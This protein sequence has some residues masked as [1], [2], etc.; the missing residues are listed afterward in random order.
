MKLK[1]VYFI[2]PVSCGGQITSASS[3]TVVG[4][5]PGQHPFEIDLEE[6]GGFPCVK[7]SRIVQGK[8][9]N[10]HVPLTNVAGFTPAD[11]PVAPAKK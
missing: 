3:G 5:R 9:S 7:L 6:S 8:M 2:N 4:D 10:V 1:N 11:A